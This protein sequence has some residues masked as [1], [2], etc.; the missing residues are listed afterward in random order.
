MLCLFSCLVMI[1]CVFS[2]FN[3]MFRLIMIYP[4]SGWHAHPYAA[5][6]NLAVVRGSGRKRMQDR[7][8]T[9]ALNI[10]L[11]LYIYIYTCIE[12]ERN[13]LCT[14]FVLHIY[15]YIYVCI[16]SK[17]RGNHATPTNLKRMR[18]SAN[19]QSE[20]RCPSSLLLLRWGLSTISP[21]IIKQVCLIC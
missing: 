17:S 18:C 13:L 14:H 16:S 5:S 1:D 7:F 19:T 8:V 20:R 10:S 12:R 3:S 6:K 2:C 21:T 11:S 15:I 9:G 4:P